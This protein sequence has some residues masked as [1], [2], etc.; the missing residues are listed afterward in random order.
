M[1][2]ALIGAVAE[3]LPSWI[4]AQLPAPARA[5]RNPSRFCV[6]RETTGA[7]KGVLENFPEIVSFR[8]LVIIGF[9]QGRP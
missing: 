8:M 9:T 6:R 5:A 4:T 1:G 3:A 2:W 7:I